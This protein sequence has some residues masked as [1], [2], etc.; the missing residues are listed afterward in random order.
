MRLLI[1]MTVVHCF[2]CLFCLFSVYRIRKLTIS[3]GLWV[4]L[5]FSCIVM[6]HCFY[7][8][9]KIILK[10]HDH[11]LLNF[12]NMCEKIARTWPTA[13]CYCYWVRSTILEFEIFIYQLESYGNIGMN[14]WC[15]I[16]YRYCNNVVVLLYYTKKKWMNKLNF[17]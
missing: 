17:W 6:L 2:V 4:F 12:L 14:N 15:D 1:R 3:Y 10:I 13:L 9:C 8:V 5:D 16:K 11:P 7:T